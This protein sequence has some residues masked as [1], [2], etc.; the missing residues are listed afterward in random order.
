VVVLM[1]LMHACVE[2]NA[3]CPDIRVLLFVRENMFDRVRHID[4][5]FSR[6]ET[7]VISLEWTRELLREFI[8]RR[9]RRQLITKPALGGPTWNAFFENSAETRAE[10]VVFHFCQYRP[11]DL[12]TYCSFALQIAQ[13]KRVVLAVLWGCQS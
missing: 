10:D 12:L 2:L 9:L 11:R 8:E 13:C 4:L 6:L 1:A 7:S 5:E 3:V